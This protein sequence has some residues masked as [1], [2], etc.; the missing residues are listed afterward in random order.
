MVKSNRLAISKFRSQIIFQRYSWFYILHLPR[1]FVLGATKK[2]HDYDIIFLGR[3]IKGTF[4]IEVKRQ[5]VTWCLFTNWLL[6]SFI[7]S[8]IFGLKTLKEALELCYAKW[9]NLISVFNHVNKCF[10]RKILLRQV[11][12]LKSLE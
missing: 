2:R 7:V 6:F 12:V 1:L 11:I 3:K 8:R 9:K 4:S 5:V 10:F